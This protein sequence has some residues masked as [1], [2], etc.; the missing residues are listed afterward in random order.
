MNIPSTE[1]KTIESIDSR[2]E[3]IITDKDLDDVQ[4][5]NLFVW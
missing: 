2:F 3:M 5:P 4:L 1:N